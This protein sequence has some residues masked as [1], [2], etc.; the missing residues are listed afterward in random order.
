MSKFYFKNTK[1][2]FFI[3]DYVKISVNSSFLT[4]FCHFSKFLGC[5]IIKKLL[6]IILAVLF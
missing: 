2:Y 5:L 1:L 3:V 4:H 6:C